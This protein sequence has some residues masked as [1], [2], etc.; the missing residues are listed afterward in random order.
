LVTFDQFSQKFQ[1][2]GGNMTFVVGNSSH[3]SGNGLVIST[4][5]GLGVFEGTPVSGGCLKT[6]GNNVAT[7]LYWEHKENVDPLSDQPRTIVSNL[8]LV[9][10]NQSRIHTLAAHETADGFVDT[11]SDQSGLDLTL[12]AASYN[13]SELF[14]TPGS[15]TT[16][17]TETIQID[18]DSNIELCESNSLSISPE[19]LSLIRTVH[20]DGSSNERT[21]Y[22]TSPMTSNSSPA[23]LAVS[24]SS[25]HSSPDCPAWRVFDQ[26]EAHSLDPQECW[27]ASSPASE[28]NPQWIQIDFGVGESVVINKY[29]LLSR[30]SSDPAY[31]S[32]PRDLELSGSNDSA[33]WVKLNS[34]NDFAQLPSNTWSD[35]LTFA[36]G[37]GYRHYR[38]SIK[39]S[40]GEGLT[41]LSQLQLVEA[42]FSVP[43]SL[44]VASILGI[45]TSG[46]SAITNISPCYSAP[47]S[48]T[49]YY[50]LSFN[51]ND[52]SENWKVLDG[53][54]WKSVARINSGDWQFMNES[55]TWTDA[56]Q[57]T[58]C[59]ALKQ[60]L[61]IDTNQMNG[62]V[63]D[64]ID[65]AWSEV[66]VA[67]EIAIATG[68]MALE[69]N[70]VPH[71][72]GFTI[73]YDTNGP[74]FELVSQ[75]CEARSDITRVDGSMLVRNM[76][77]SV[78]LWISL[79]EG[80][81]SWIELSGLTKT[82]NF[83][84][85]I[86]LYSACATDL[87]VSSGTVRARITA[88]AGTETEIHGWAINW[89][90]Y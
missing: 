12:T 69:N 46:W 85:E 34:R 5:N 33:N 8:H 38:L 23:P 22:S 36:N 64:A 29:R 53:V 42:S 86:E 57:N 83:A 9:H 7:D 76:N 59:S 45:P 71:L 62:Q 78:R 37:Y 16:G 6:S 87:N 75:A 56:E 52:D 51:N 79:V 61:E 30:N 11:F 55:G 27:I 50:A 39:R 44:Q 17:L 49:I 20:A 89:G 41:S 48:S 74:D 2:D 18:Q 14:Y 66:F 15:A 67:G 81:P 88:N 90:A 19:G 1:H 72:G 84:P 80:P 63:L 82:A 4:E 35:Y 43:G 40:W 73:S 13:D 31:V 28:T 58:R 47:G 60:A 10:L 25:E 77:G 21:E 68:M 70:N 32:P 24:A 65:E 54:D 26:N 3:L